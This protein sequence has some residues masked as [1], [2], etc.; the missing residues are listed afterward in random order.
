M[1]ILPYK[2]V[3]VAD[4]L[5][6]KMSNHYRYTDFGIR[7]SGEMRY[8]GRRYV[9]GDTPGTGFI[10]RESESHSYHQFVR[11]K[12][13]VQ[14]PNYWRMLLGK[15]PDYDK[16]LAE[17]NKALMEATDKRKRELLE[18]YVNALTVARKAEHAERV[19]R[20]IKDKM[21]HHSDKFMVSVISHYKG[22]IRQL[23]HDMYAVQWQV[24]EHYSP[25]IYQAYTDMVHAFTRVASCRRIWQLNTEKR[26]QYD[27]VYFD[28][29]VFD[30]IRNESYLP[31]MRDNKGR[32]IYILPD[33]VIVAR[34]AVDFDL[35]PL[36]TMT[37]VC[38]ELAIEEPTEDVLSS[39]GDA[40]SMIKIPELDL[41]FYFNHYHSVA[42]F[43]HAVDKLKSLL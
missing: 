18:S 16:A 34:S 31:L 32:E 8:T 4:G 40:A 25:E 28:L 5:H 14:K 19:V 15:E 13:S 3:K 41:N 24:K 43:V 27:Q 22:K 12:V 38:Q 37:L 2:W 42:D 36:K 6:V 29:G 21:G 7:D 23:E 17:A 30:Y 39:I 35:L 33:V 10:E 20:A 11:N 9:A 26:H 1:K